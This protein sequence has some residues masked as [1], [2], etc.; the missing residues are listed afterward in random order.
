MAEGRAG[1]LRGPRPESEPRS[2]TST[3][4]RRPRMRLST[5][6][7]SHIVCTRHSSSCPVPSSASSSST[8]SKVKASP[9]SA[10]DWEYASRGRFGFMSVPWR[11]FGRRW[12][13][14]S[15]RG[16]CP[17]RLPREPFLGPAQSPI[18]VELVLSPFEAEQFLFLAREVSP[19]LTA[20]RAEREV[21]GA[22]GIGIPIP[23]FSRAGRARALADGGRDLLS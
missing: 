9:T 4:R 1:L 19:Y 6:G 11:S 8:I 21:G 22:P 15:S 10:P 18:K 13:L 23:P 5:D 16:G 12:E 14:I 3:N 2:R 17:A 7:D 20:G